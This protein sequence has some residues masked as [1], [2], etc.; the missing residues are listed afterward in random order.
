MKRALALALLAAAILLLLLG[1]PPAARPAGAVQPRKPDRLQLRRRGQPLDVILITIDTLRADALGFAGN[2]RSETPVLDRL[3]AGGRVFLDAHAHNVVTLPSHTNILTG[4]YPYQH[5]VRDNSGFVLSPAVATLGT[6]FRSAGYA[7][8]AFVGGFPLTAQ[9]GLNHGFDV[10]DDRT[11]RDPEGELFGLAERRGG[12]VV[13]A[14][15]AWWRRERG[16]PRLLWVHLFDPHAPY[17]PPEPFASRFADNL[18]LG[19]VAAADSFLAPLLNPFVEGREPAPFIVFTSDH[20]ESLGEHGE[21]THGLFA[22]ESTLK[23][24]LVIWGPG[25]T[26]GRDPRLARHIDIFPTL[27]QAAGIPPPPAPTGCVRRALPGRS[28]LAPAMPGGEDSYFEALSAT[29]NRRWAPLRGTLRGDRKFIALPLPEVYDLAHDPAEERNLFAGEGV[30]A[31][32][33]FATLPRESSWPRPGK[34]LTAEDTARLEGL[35]YLASSGPL[36]LPARFGPRDDPKTL[37]DLDRKMQEAIHDFAR[38]D[39]EAAIR[40]ARAVVAERPDMPLGHSLL[41]QALLASGHEQEALAVMEEARRRGLASEDL[42]RQLGLALANAGRTDEAIAVLRPLAARASPQSLSAL[43]GALSRA[44]KQEEAAATARR[45][46]ALSPDSVRG[47]DLLGLIDIRRGRLEE[48]RAEL[49]RAVQA[50]P[51]LA[52]A[53]NDLGVALYQLHQ[54]A[55]AFQAWQRAIDLQPKLWDTLWNLGT[56]AAEQGLTQQARAALER[57]V[58][59]APRQRYAAEVKQARQFLSALSRA[60]PGG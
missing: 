51:R 17:A 57:F 32:A 21:L 45:L 48:A 7:T 9:F 8:G 23:V 42:L 5:G 47:H 59:G 35:G 28:L 24:P 39:S 60:A 34:E 38:G 4:L 30:A 1:R 14:A 16:R 22:Y 27:L 40:L 25:V 55:P 10:Y 52:V 56:K 20:G 44:G 46:L 36:R 29:F 18:Y 54:L 13:A 19:E 15:L 6:V 11:S 50:D 43:A 2:R 37:V 49:Q 31:R 58:A 12:D 33:A 41:A 26:P 53:W 3:A